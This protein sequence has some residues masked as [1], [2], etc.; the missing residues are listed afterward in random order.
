MVSENLVL[1]PSV[2][3]GLSEWTAWSENE[4]SVKASYDA[5]ESYDSEKGSLRVVSTRRGKWSLTQNRLVSVKPKE[6]FLIAA[7]VKSQ[8]HERTSYAMMSSTPL[9]LEFRRVPIFGPP[10][11]DPSEPFKV[12]F[13]GQWSAGKLAITGCW[14]WREMQGFFSVPHGVY[15]LQLSLNGQG[16]GIAWFDALSLKRGIP[17]DVNTQPSDSPSARTYPEAVLFRKVALG[18]YA[19]RNLRVG[20]IDGD[21]KTEF[22]IAQNMDIGH[23]EHVITCLTA[24]DL[25]GK[26]L[27]QIGEPDLRNFRTTSDVPLQLYDIDG[28]GKCE[29]IYCRDFRIIIGDGATGE[30]LAEARN[31]RSRVGYG[32]G[33]PPSFPETQ[34]D[35]ITVCN[36]SGSTRPQELILKD[37]YNNL[38]AYDKDLNQ[39]WSYTGKTSHFVVSCDVNGD[40]K[41]EVFSGDA[42]IN[43]NGKPLWTIDLYDH[44]D[45]MV[46]GDIDDEPGPDLVMANQTGGFYFLD[47]LTGRIKKEWHLGHAQGT[48]L[49]K[50]RSDIK[51][52]QIV[53]QTYWGGAYWFMFDRNGKIIEADFDCVYGWVPVNWTGDGEELMATPEG[54][55]DGHRR[56]VVPFP[57]LSEQSLDTKFW[58]HDICGDPRDEVIRYGT[59]NVD[60]F[61]Q[62]RPFTGEEIYV[63][64]RRLYN[65]TFYASFQSEP[66]WQAY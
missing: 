32:F 20:D 11:G 25:R 53:A 24:I 1:D 15:W 5:N 45:S 49:A 37:R 48:T 42:M 18:E 31:P 2:Q 35:S 34:G 22:V 38:W 30:I 16:P 60:I 12:T 62:S 8:F 59:K 23:D 19:G 26:V 6:L 13:L 50:F 44:C 43:P 58:V 66:A 65:Q 33:S 52:L 14:K 57:D 3:G 56:L 41:D 10:L 28:D 39:L 63:P 54:L 64:R 46:V 40:G 7:A 51:G 21:G 9:D 4:G 61:T 36:L 17:E 47:A 55:Y 29:V 27:W